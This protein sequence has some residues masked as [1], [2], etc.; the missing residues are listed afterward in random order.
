MSF[1][2]PM[3]RERFFLLVSVFANVAFK[4]FYFG[5][6]F[7]MRPEV[8][9]GFESFVAYIT[10]ETPISVDIPDVESE[11]FLCLVTKEKKK[12]Q[13]KRMFSLTCLRTLDSVHDCT[14]P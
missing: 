6:C 1:H 10:L 14:H 5:V 8:D 12:I 2:V 13:I 7:F 3:L 11:V 4:S 9:V